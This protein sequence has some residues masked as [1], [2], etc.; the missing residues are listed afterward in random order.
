VVMGGATV[1]EEEPGRYRVEVT[2]G[3]RA[4]TGWGAP[5]DVTSGALAAA[6]TSW[7]AERGVALRDLRVGR[8]LEDAYLDVLRAHDE[9]AEPDARRER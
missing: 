6:V 2:V 3:A 9:A 5:P 4:A 8:S 7:L 1:T